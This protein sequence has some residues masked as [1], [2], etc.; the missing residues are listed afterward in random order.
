MYNG[1]ISTLLIYPT[2]YLNAPFLP[3]DYLV[4]KP[5]FFFFFFFSFFIF[6]FF[7]FLLCY[8]LVDILFFFF[9][10]SSFSMLIDCLLL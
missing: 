1:I 5:F 9:F 10:V 3:C 2:K 6:F 8:Y 4:D 7:F